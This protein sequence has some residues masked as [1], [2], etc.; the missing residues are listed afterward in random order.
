V[1]D[2]RTIIQAVEAKHRAY[3][4]AVGRAYAAQSPARATSGTANQS[5]TLTNRL[6]ADPPN[7]RRE[8]LGLEARRQR[9]IEILRNGERGR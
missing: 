8:S 6:D 9:A 7:E 4:E 1:D 3:H 2:Y 5:K